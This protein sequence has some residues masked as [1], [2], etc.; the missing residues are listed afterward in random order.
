M[1]ADDEQP[2]PVLG[3][4]TRWYWLVGITLAALIAAFAVLT[5]V[6]NR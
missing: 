5:H 4:W 1:A 3:T 6:Y 2:P